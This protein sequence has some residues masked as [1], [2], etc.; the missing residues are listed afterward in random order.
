MKLYFVTGMVNA[1]EEGDGM[2]TE[3]HW[4]ASKA[5]TATIRAEMI[6]KGATRKGISTIEVDVPTNKE[7]LLRFLNLLTVSPTVAVAAER[8]LQK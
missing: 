8:L 5:E 6:R 4:V 7:G 3:S 2:V 1:P